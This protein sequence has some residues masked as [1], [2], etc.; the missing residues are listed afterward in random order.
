MAVVL[1]VVLDRE[2]RLRSV[3]HHLVREER[4][5]YAAELAQATAERVRVSVDALTSYQATQQAALRERF[6]RIAV[7]GLRI[8]QLEAMLARCEALSG[9]LRV[10]LESLRAAGPEKRGARDAPVAGAPECSSMAS[11]V[12]PSPA[13]V[14]P[15]ARED[16][17]VGADEEATHVEGR[18]TVIPAASRRTVVGLGA[19]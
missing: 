11:G 17:R 2:R 16:E 12:R 7:A 3:V 13:V 18:V 1:V 15:E 14:A 8:G 9:E 5:R 10:A 4:E 19:S 6:A